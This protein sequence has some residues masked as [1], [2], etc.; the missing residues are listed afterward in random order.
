MSCSF[1]WDAPLGRPGGRGPAPGADLSCQ[2]GFG[3]I[4]EGINFFL[5]VARPQTGSRELLSPDLIR[6]QGR[7]AYSEKRIPDSAEEG[8]NLLYVVTRPQTGGRNL[9]CLDP[10]GELGGV[11]VRL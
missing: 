7:F 8:V 6:R 9:P 4:E 2:P 10:L 11:N 3:L 5:V 1:A